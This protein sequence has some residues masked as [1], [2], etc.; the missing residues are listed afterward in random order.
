MEIKNNLIALGLNTDNAI[1]I[2]SGILN[3]LNLRESK[4][5]DVVVT[6]EKYWELAGNNRFRKLQNHGSEILDDGLF[7][8]RTSWTVIGKAWGFEDLL[9][10]STIIDNVR[11]NAV[12]FLLDVKRRWIMEGIG[13][14]KDYNDVKLM[15]HYLSD[16][17]VA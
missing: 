12:E 10:Y 14:E 9:Y 13:R 6:E 1:V 11:Y 7:E 5:I 2:G 15:E 16:S 8:I 3:A 4:D 17:E